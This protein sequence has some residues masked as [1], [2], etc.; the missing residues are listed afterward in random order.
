MITDFSNC[1]MVSNTKLIHSLRFNIKQVRLD[2]K[3][4]GNIRKHFNDHFLLLKDKELQNKINDSKYD[5]KTSYLDPKF[6]HRLDKD[7]LL[8]RNAC[9]SANVEHL[10]YNKNRDT[11]ATMMFNVM[12]ENKIIE[13]VSEDSYPTMNK[14]PVT[15]TV[16]KFIN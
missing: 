3:V 8:I 5:Y 2:S 7:S 15:T 10:V 11:W 6:R 13:E 1:L 14:K 9:K 16:Y 12:L 4:Y